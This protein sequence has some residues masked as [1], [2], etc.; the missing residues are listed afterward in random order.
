M[1]LHGRE[2]CKSKYKR[3]KF[4]LFV[5][6]INTVTLYILTLH[7]PVTTSHEVLSLANESKPINLALG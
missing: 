4:P 1:Y 5:G 2:I 7:R 6:S 3:R